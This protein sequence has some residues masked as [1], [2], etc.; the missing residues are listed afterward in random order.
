MPRCSPLD[1]DVTGATIGG[2]CAIGSAAA[3]FAATDVGSGGDWGVRPPD[4][5]SV[6]TTTRSR[7]NV[8]SLATP[9]SDGRRPPPGARPRQTG[10]ALT[11]GEPNATAPR[12]GEAAAT[13]TLQLDL[14][15]AVIAGVGA[16]AARQP[17][18]LA[19]PA[20]WYNPAASR[21]PAPQHPARAHRRVARQRP[22]TKVIGQLDFQSAVG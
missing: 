2:P 5:H 7:R 12:D 21:A 6:R 22:G 11:I 10:C 15:P 17:E 4:R 13:H 3:G 16:C 20:R 18:G 14:H 9:V 8:S 19:L 1:A